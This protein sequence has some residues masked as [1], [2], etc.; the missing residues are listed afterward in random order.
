MIIIIIMSKCRPVAMGGG[1]G[2]GGGHRDPP[3]PPPPPPRPPPP[4][5]PSPTP[6]FLYWAKTGCR[7]SKTII[8]T[9]F[10]GLNHVLECAGHPRTG[11]HQTKIRLATPPSAAREPPFRSPGYGALSWMCKCQRDAKRPPIRRLAPAIRHDH[12]S[13][14]SKPRRSNISG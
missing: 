7:L 10:S 13:S 14:K 5:T 12:I 1:G 6:H 8:L 9:R 3:P 11:P 2:W 4:T